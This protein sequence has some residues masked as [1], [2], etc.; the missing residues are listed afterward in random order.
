MV[1]Q[2]TAAAVIPAAQTPAPG[3]GTSPLAFSPA[4]SQLVIKDA[5]LSL[6]VKDSAQAMDE[7]TALTSQEG[8]YIISSKTWYQDGY[9]Y[10]ALRLGIP[11]IRFETA[12]NA[13]RRIGVQ[14]LSENAQGQDITDQYVDLQSRQTNLEA[15]AAR[16]RE[17]LK[18]AKTIEDSLRINQQLAEL[19]DQINQ[20]KGQMN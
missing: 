8:G 13:L 6:L 17:F 7:V 5:E 12:L 18:D 19:E 2:P 16:V 15:T 10:A 3:Q 4:G 20:V 1:A 11:S 14:G 9:L